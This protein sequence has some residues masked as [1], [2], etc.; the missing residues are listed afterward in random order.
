METKRS[1]RGLTNA[2]LQDLIK[3]ITLSDFKGV[4]PQN[5]GDSIFTDEERASV[6]LN[7]DFS[8]EKG[9]HFVGIYKKS[10]RIIYF[11]SYGEEPENFTKDFLKKFNIPLIINKVKIQSKLSEFCGYYTA[12]FIL[13]QDIGL[14]LNDFTNLFITGEDNKLI[15]NDKLVIFFIQN[16]IKNFKI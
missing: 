1:E 10:D 7:L 11:D 8:Y 2:Y 14:E 12:A 4:F 13:S 16:Y 3:N 15:A 6:V 9:S 5:L